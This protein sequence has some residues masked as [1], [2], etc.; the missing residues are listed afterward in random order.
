MLLEMGK[1]VAVE[2]DCLWVETIQKLTC[3]SCA[4]QKGCGQSLLAKLGAK[5]SY[6]RVLLSEQFAGVNF[7]QGDQ[8]EIGIPETVVVNGSLVAYGLPLVM[9]ILM[10]AI[11]NQVF[12][13]EVY[14]I[15]LA[16]AGLVLGGLF[17]RVAAFFS[18]NKQQFQ[19]VLV[20]VLLASPELVRPLSV[21]NSD[22]AG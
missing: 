3:G 17:V 15:L 19:P 4:A 22:T 2:P 9:F 8:V 13:H 16:F 20:N 1:V 7:K 14:V 18:R 21:I 10:A 11:G 5:S 12:A 6:L